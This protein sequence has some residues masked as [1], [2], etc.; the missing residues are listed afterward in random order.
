M[1]QPVWAGGLG[2]DLRSVG[3]GDDPFVG[4]PLSIIHALLD[5]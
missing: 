2:T 4:V 3:Q 5:E 1:G